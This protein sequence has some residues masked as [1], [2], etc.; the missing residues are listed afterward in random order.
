MFRWLGSQD[1]WL[2]IIVGVLLG[3]IVSAAVLSGLAWLGWTW[4]TGGV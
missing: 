1:V 2:Q 4:V 3:L